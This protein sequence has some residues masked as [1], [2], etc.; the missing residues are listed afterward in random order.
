MQFEEFKEGQTLIA[1]DDILNL[2]NKVCFRKGEKVYAED[3]TVISRGG[4][5]ATE[6]VVSNG[7]K[8]ETV[9]LGPFDNPFKPVEE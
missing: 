1:T 2:Q 7:K 6:A 5:I 4:M 3:V 8:K 9:L